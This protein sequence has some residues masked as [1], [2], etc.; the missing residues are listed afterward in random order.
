MI[1]RWREYRVPPPSP[2]A[3]WFLPP[4]RDARAH[5]ALLRSAG[6]VTGSIAKS[7]A[8]PGMR[9]GEPRRRPTR[10]PRHQQH[11]QIGVA[12]AHSRSH[13]AIMRPQARRLQTPKAGKN[14]NPHA[15]FLAEERHQAQHV[16]ARRAP[17]ATR[18]PSSL[19]RL[20]KNGVRDHACTSPLAASVSGQCGETRQKSM[21][22]KSPPVA[23]SGSRWIQPSKG[24]RILVGGLL[25][26]N[27]LEAI[28]SLMLCSNGE[29]FALRANQDLPLN[30]HRHERVGRVRPQEPR[31]LSRP[32]HPASPPT[33]PDDLQPPP[34][35]PICRFAPMGGRVANWGTRHRMTP[36]PFPAGQVVDGTNA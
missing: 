2:A 33:T 6:A 14:S 20:A 31:V 24:R 12:G 17:S 5:R 10:T 27:R 7:A 21:E 13:R 28:F 9:P 11:Q 36:R 3:C 29:R 1:V 16:A 26:G 35:G 19:V 4:R 34:R 25:V 18:T 23:Y 8:W 32:R 22:M 30:G 15:W